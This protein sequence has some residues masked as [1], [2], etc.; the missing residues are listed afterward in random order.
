MDAPPDYD[1]PSRHTSLPAGT[2]SSSSTAIIPAVVLSAAEEKEQ[3]RKRYEQAQSAISSNPGGGS[4]SQTA[5]GF[6]A[7]GSGPALSKQPTYLSAAEE[8]EIQKKRFEEASARVGGTAPPNTAGDAGAAGMPWTHLSAAEEKELQRKR[9]E[10]ARRGGGG[11]DLGHGSM[12]SRAVSPAPTSIMNGHS[13]SAPTH[14][15]GEQPVPYDAVFPPR[16]PASVTAS[17]QRT[18]HANE[19]TTPV[20]GGHAELSD[21]EAMNR[22]FYAKDRRSSRIVSNPSSTPTPA[23]PPS[24]RPVSSGAATPPI[25]SSSSMALSGNEAMKR[26]YD[27]Q[28]RGDRSVVSPISKDQEAPPPFAAGSGSTRAM[29]VAGPP[30]TLPVDEKAQMK[31][32]YEALDRVNNAQSPGGVGGA[33]G[34][35]SGNSRAQDVSGPMSRASVVHQPPAIDASSSTARVVSSGSQAYLSA[36][37][38]KELMRN[39]FEQ[40]TAA[41]SRTQASETRSSQANGW[42]APP[43]A[44][45]GSGSS[46]A[47]PQ[48]QVQETLKGYL[49]AAEEKE[50]MRRRF[51]D[52][53]AAVNRNSGGQPPL[54]S[55]ELYD[56]P[57]PPM[58]SSAATASGSSSQKPVV[59]YMSAAEEK[60]QM[61][62]RFEDATAA[63]NRKSTQ[64]PPP[65]SYD[66][67][68]P[69]TFPSS[70]A[71]SSSTASTSKPAAPYLSAAEE[72]E[73]M[74]RRFEDATAAVNRK[75]T[76][77]L[78]SPE[79][80]NSTPP[81]QN[82]A[83]AGGSSSSKAN[84][85]SAYPSA[86]DEKE[87]MR[88]R[89]ESAQA[90]VSSSSSRNP[91]SS[92]PPSRSFTSPAPGLP[93]SFRQSTLPSIAQTSSGASRRSSIPPVDPDA[94]P[95]PLPARPPAEYINLLSPVEESG[96][97]APW[98]RNGAGASN[99]GSLAQASSSATQTQ[100]P[101]YDANDRGKN[102]NGQ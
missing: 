58:A 63:V 96:S 39:R 57:P 46:G 13:P 54:R 20:R 49:S 33:S 87:Q 29:P 30:P 65:Q 40:A 35:G 73:Q 86:A 59:P 44:A 82:L 2:S 8:K 37:E 67:P 70:G 24:Q 89:F 22:Y 90:A 66:S 69:P 34:S 21:K 41:V 62:R 6:G 74:R 100:V 83:T 72:K 71:G 15:P 31:R 26:Y 7:G 36:A 92:P 47:Q 43:P 68:P 18:T 23:S 4:S 80:Y 55:P 16:S 50:Q 61:R 88:L 78:Q 38:E 32:Y 84:P 64:P 102:E 98:A 42:D 51:E 17:P 81:P 14:A 94:P 27:R 12:S 60:E 53:T 97:K 101:K 95:P 9:Y 48:V 25:G 93:A 79:S 5:S 3:Q 76:A 28:A 19:S 99:F 77:P 52:A 91:I 75:S 85:P 45:S 1:T 11:S 10:D 56:S